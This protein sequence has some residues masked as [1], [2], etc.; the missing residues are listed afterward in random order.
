[1]LH[2]AYLYL[3]FFAAITAVQPVLAAE[4]TVPMRLDHGVI[5]FDAT[6][7]GKG[8]YAFILDPGA[9]DAVSGDT[10]RKLLGQIAACDRQAGRRPGES[11]LIWWNAAVGPAF[12]RRAGGGTGAW[13]RDCTKLN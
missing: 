9:Q 13:I 12:L 4:V 11:L 8:P 5:F 3:C 1:M 2:R 10:L 7:D 6:V